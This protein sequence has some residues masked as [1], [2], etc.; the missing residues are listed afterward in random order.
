M[1]GARRLVARYPAHGVDVDDAGVLVDVDTEADSRSAA[2][3]AVQ[4]S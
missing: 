2:G 4:A 1:K 3:Q